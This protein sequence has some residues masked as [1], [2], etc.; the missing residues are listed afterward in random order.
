MEQSYLPI[1][2]ENPFVNWEKEINNLNFNKT[3]DGKCFIPNG[4]QISPQMSSKLRDIML[5]MKDIKVDI[6]GVAV[7]VG[8]KALHFVFEAIRRYPNTACGLLIIATLHG[9]CRTIPFF[10][11]ILDALLIPLDV[12]IVASSFLRDLMGSESFKGFLKACEASASKALM[13]V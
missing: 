6:K 5:E 10:G 9:I 8:I 4:Q 13:A 3:A 1:Q 11:H 12:I 7:Y 2:P